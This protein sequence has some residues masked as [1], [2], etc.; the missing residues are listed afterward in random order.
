MDQTRNPKQRTDQYGRPYAGSQRLIQTYVNFRQDALNSALLS[1]IPDFPSAG[2]LVWVSPLEKDN[3]AE[4]QDRAFLEA[5]GIGHY[6]DR[7]Q[8]FWPRRGPVWDALARIENQV[9]DQVEGVVLVEAKSHIDEIYGNGCQALNQSRKLIDKAL[10][11]VKDFLGVA[12]ENDWTGPLYQSANRIAH[13]YFFREI[14]QVRAW[15]INVYFTEDPNYPTSA[16][17]WRRALP[18]VKDDLGLG[19]ITVDGLVEVVLGAGD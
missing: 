2:G 6:W 18:R 19:D 4:Y 15:L 5:L 11:K 7:L 17:S 3:F 14:C 13:L 1:A 10:G 16:D 12:A 8:S 9:T